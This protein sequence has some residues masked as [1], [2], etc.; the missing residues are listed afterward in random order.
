MKRKINTAKFTK[1][2]MNA[3]RKSEIK[4]TMILATIARNMIEITAAPKDIII[5]DGSM[6]WNRRSKNMTADPRR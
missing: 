2:E 4:T 5:C 6:V 1:K 3:G